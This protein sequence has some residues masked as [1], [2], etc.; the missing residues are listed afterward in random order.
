MRSLYCL[1]LSAVLLAVSVL[2]AQARQPAW[3]DPAT[4]MEFVWVPQGCFKMGDTFGVADSDEKPV[5]EVCVDGFWLGKHAVTQAQWTKVLGDNPSKFK[6]DD[7]HPVD[8]ISW[9]DAKR[10]A[11]RLSALS[12]GAE[13]YRL[14]TEAEWEY[15][16]RS[17]GKHE[18]FAGG[19]DAAKVAWYRANS[20]G[21]THPVGLREPN[22]LGLYDMSGNVYQ[23]VE[24]MYEKDAYARHGRNNPVQTT[25]WGRVA[26]GGWWGGEANCVRCTFRC[27]QS[28]RCKPASTGMRLVRMGPNP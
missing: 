24:D 23:W 10:F 5:H 28:D 20:Q 2:S 1:G 11:A 27:Y 17:G 6:A 22:G 19:A 3:T 4:D 13:R 7:R 18:M 15:A 25:G 8:S 9:D 21:S 26:R 12:K 14:P 16:C